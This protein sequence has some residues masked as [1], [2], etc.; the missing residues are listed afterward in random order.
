VEERIGHVGL[1]LSP[2]QGR[3]VVYAVIES[4]QMGGHTA[5]Y[6]VEFP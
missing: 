1:D 4:Q 5:L 6:V 3:G 2:D